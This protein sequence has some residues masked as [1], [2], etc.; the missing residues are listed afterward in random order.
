MTVSVTL[1][2]VERQEA[3]RPIFQADLHNYAGIVHKASLRQSPDYHRL[4]PASRCHFIPILTAGRQ[5]W[6]LC[7][8]TDEPEN[9]GAF[10]T[11]APRTWNQLPTELKR[12]QSTSAFR[13]GLTFFSIVHTA[14][15]NT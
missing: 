14:P 9:G 8:A 13:R 4:T 6:R 3:R 10:S 11:A 2:D 5:S 7:R 1:N 15:N 12:T